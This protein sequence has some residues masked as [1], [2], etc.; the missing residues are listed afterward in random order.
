M[1]SIKHKAVMKDEQRGSPFIGQTKAWLALSRILS[2][3][4][5]SIM[6][7]NDEKRTKSDK[8]RRFTAH[9]CPFLFLLMI[10]DYS[11]TTS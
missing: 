1:I 2:A 5:E 7:C 10:A 11:T 8:G 3:M 9:R 4:L 6:L